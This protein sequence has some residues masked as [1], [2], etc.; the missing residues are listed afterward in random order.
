MFCLHFFCSTSWQEEREF[1]LNYSVKTQ[2]P[3]A[4]VKENSLSV[5]SFVF[6]LYL[7]A[8]D[9]C[10]LVTTSKCGRLGA[11]RNTFWRQIKRGQKFGGKLAS[12]RCEIANRPRHE[13]SSPCQIKS[14]NYNTEGRAAT[15][16]LQF[17]RCMI[18][19][20]LILISILVSPAAFKFWIYISEAGPLFVI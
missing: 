10:V 4:A 6:N 20:R 2:L 17:V 11:K 7:L 16:Q 1:G 5:D 19:R 8:R 9:V 13:G 15:F 18:P 3:C 14:R 12:D